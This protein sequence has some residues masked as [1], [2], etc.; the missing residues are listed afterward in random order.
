MESGAGVPAPLIDRSRD[1]DVLEKCADRVVSLHPPSVHSLLTT[2][3]FVHLDFAFIP[4]SRR[5]G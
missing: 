2:L 4:P 5:E 1:S 3:W